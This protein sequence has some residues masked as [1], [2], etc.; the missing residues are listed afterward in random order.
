MG[1]PAAAP[2]SFSRLKSYKQCPRQFHAEKVLKL[3]PFK[4]T[5]AIIYGSQF[6]EAAE[7]YVRDGTPMPPHFDYA[8]P[9]ID[10]LIAKDGEKFCEYE[11]G[12]TAD[13]E[14]CDFKAENVWVRGIIDLLIIDREKGM[15]WVIDYKT[16]GNT[17]WADTSQLE[18]MALLLFKH[19]PEIKRVQAGLLFVVVNQLIKTKYHVRDQGKLWQRWMKDYALMEN[20]FDKNIWNAHPSGLCR[21]HC[22]VT[23]CPHNGA[24]D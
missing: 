23:E 14:P 9:A 24:N 7:L 1:K 12:L 8:K 10:N 18:L 2:W 20:S 5:E 22:P 13:M 21:R 19:F 15:A 16:G 4:E 17:R 3:Y 11:M 6:H